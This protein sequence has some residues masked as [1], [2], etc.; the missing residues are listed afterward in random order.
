MRYHGTHS[1][2][3]EGAIDLIGPT[4]QRE[5]RSKKYFDDEC[6]DCLQ[7]RRDAESAAA[8]ARAAEMGLPALIGTPKQ[9]AWAETRRMQFCDAMDTIK[10]DRRF[11]QAEDELRAAAEYILA[12]ERYA[13]WWIENRTPDNFFLAEYY[14]KHEAKIKA[15][16]DSSATATPET[17]CDESEV[18][19]PAT[20]AHDGIVTVGLLQ[21]GETSWTIAARYEKNDAFREIVK[22]CRLNWDGAN[23]CWARSIGILS[24]PG[25][26]RAAELISR[27]LEAG[28]CVACYDAGVRELVL[29]GA[30]KPEIRCWVAFKREGVVRFK[31]DRYDRLNENVRRLGARWDGEGYEI[32]ADKYLKIEEFA[33]LYGFSITPN[34]QKALD[35][36]REKIEGAKVVD[37]AIVP[38]LKPK[39]NP[40]AEILKSSDEVL[41]DLRDDG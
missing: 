20:I 5:W 31:F 35:A 38:A 36:A 41:P 16:M 39:D 40:L 12:N 21:R 33:R 9:V 30:Y 14:Q 1:C 25:P 24:G 6:P 17:P 22:R 11:N 2:G 28:F 23:R 8:A 13:S 15:Y 10:P 7:K 4:S 19:R 34:A 29:S 3:H 27:L 26:D 37:P 18:M 32:G